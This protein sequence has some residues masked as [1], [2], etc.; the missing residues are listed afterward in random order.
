MSVLPAVSSLRAP[1]EFA[2]EN[3]A[4][5][6]YVGFGDPLL[7]GEPEKATDER[8]K[9]NIIARAQA[10]RDLQCEQVQPRQIAMSDVEG[11]GSII[12]GPDGLANV[13]SL[14]KWAPLPETAVEI[15]DVANKIGDS[16]SAR[17]GHP[18]GMQHRGRECEECRISLRSRARLLLC[19]GAVAA[20]LALVGGF[21]RNRGAHY[22]RCREI[23]IRSRHRPR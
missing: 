21:L 10:A 17:L 22:R 16:S 3:H 7:D 2:K 14:R 18:L 19:R 12:R 8:T 15:C 13:A 1:R 6:T 9:A 20:G 11:G 5:E 23:E 4:K